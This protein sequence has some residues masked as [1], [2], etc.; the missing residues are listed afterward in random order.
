MSSSSSAKRKY[1]RRKLSSSNESSTSE[2]LSSTN[3]TMSGGHISIFPSSPLVTVAID[4]KKNLEG[5]ST[6]N[7]IMDCGNLDLLASVTENVD[8]VDRVGI[9]QEQIGTLSPVSIVPPVD[10]SCT[11]STC[12][13][14]TEV[15]EAVVKEQTKR[16]GGGGGGGARKRKSTSSSSATQRPTATNITSSNRYMSALLNLI[17]HTC[18]LNGREIDYYKPLYMYVCVCVLYGVL[19]EVS[20]SKRRG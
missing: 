16:K 9:G 12:L 8:Q 5:P 20:H 10:I 3:E 13:D 17:T 6:L 2:A 19:T 1:R 18:T 4:T 15:P 7:E 11:T 14:V